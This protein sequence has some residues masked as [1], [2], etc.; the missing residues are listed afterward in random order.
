M[1][2]K[3]SSTKINEID[4][5][6]LKAIE[7]EVRAILKKYPNSGA[8]LIM[9]TGESDEFLICGNMC[10][11]CAAEKLIAFIEMTGAKHTI[12][13]IADESDEVH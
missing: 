8:V 7:D 10:K 9:N 11:V 1:R 4:D 5:P 12:K 13:L 3:P 2:K 6:N